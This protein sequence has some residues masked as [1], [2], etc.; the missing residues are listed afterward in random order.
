MNR[1]ERHTTEGV[2]SG[3][4]AAEQGALQ[5][6]A[7]DYGIELARDATVYVTEITGETR[8]S[9]FRRATE[10]FRVRIAL[11]LAD[12]VLLLAITGESGIS[13][14]H[15]RMRDLQA[16]S[17][18][19]SLPGVE[20]GSRLARK[21]EELGGD[22]VDLAGFR[23]SGEDTAATGSYFLQVGPPDGE[24]AKAAITSAVARGS[25]GE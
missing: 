8:R 22:G 7:R 6:C 24:R 4:S 20:P 5:A 19:D 17:A 1:R 23:V 2:L 16:S 14:L 12:P 25:S 21:L 15:A 11:V 9:V 18:A 3:L 13:V 10:Q